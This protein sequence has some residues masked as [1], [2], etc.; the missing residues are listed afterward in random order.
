[1]HVLGVEINNWYVVYREASRHLL[2]K[3]LCFQTLCVFAITWGA[4]LASKDIGDLKKPEYTY[5]L[6]RDNSKYDWIDWLFILLALMVM[7]EYVTLLIS[8]ND[9]AYASGEERSGTLFYLIRYPFLILL[10]YQFYRHTHKK[11]VRRT[12]ILGGFVMLSVFLLG[13][14]YAIVPILLGLMF[15][16]FVIKNTKIDLTY[17][18]KILL[19]IA[20]LLFLSLMKGWTHLRNYPLSELNWK[21]V[22]EAYSTSLLQ[23]LYDTLAEMGKTINTI[24]STISAVD[25]GNLKNDRTILYALFVGVV[26]ES[27]ANAFKLTPEIK[28]L[29]SWVTKIIGVRNGQ[30]Y[31]IFAEAYFNYH[32]FGF[33]FLFLFGYVFVKLENQAVKLF[34][35]DNSSMTMLGCGILYL[36]SYATFLARADL[37]LMASYIRFIVYIYA[38]IVIKRRGILLLNNK[39]NYNSTR[40]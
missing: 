16:A 22:Q 23:G 24:V 6:R 39:R 8:R 3:T 40:R 12:Y 18:Q 11:W 27:V 19:V 7:Y 26:P 32:N 9:F 5:A 28:S 33:L 15:I 36:I 37:I 17:K 38:I 35:S 29:A 2:M 13:A 1:M 14:R 10:Y 21:L 31:S 30:G 25:A 4:V 34:N 20:G